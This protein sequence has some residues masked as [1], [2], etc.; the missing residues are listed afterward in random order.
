MLFENQ[1]LKP[2]WLWT[3]FTLIPSVLS[4]SKHPIL[5]VVSF[6]AFRYNFFDTEQLPYMELIRHKGVYA[7]FLVNVFPTKTFTNHH[8]ISTGLYAESH[9]VVGNSFYDPLYKKVIKIGPEMYNYNVDVKP[10]W[11]LNE[12]MGDERYSATVMWPG[13]IFS[14][15]NKNV[16]WRLPFESGYDWHERVDHVITWITDPNKPANLVM[17]YF[18]EPDTHGHAFGPNSPVVKDLIHKLDNI[19]GYLNQQ[20]NSHGLSENV[21]VIFVSDHGMTAVTPP[22]FLN[23]TQYITN[24]TYIW[25]GVSPVI[26]IIPN[27]GFHDTI[28]NSL[29]AAAKENGHFKV[30]NKSEYLERWHLKNN[31]RAAPILVVADIG[32]AFDDLIRDAPKYAEKYNFTL[33]NSSEFGVHGYDYMEPEMHPYFMAIGPKIKQQTKV[34]PFQTVDLFNVFCAILDIPPTD[35]NGT[36][37]PVQQ[38]LQETTGKYSIGTVVMISGGFSFY[39]KLQTIILFVFLTEVIVFQH[40]GFQILVIICVLFLKFYFLFYHLNKVFDI[41]SVFNVCIQGFINRTRIIYDISA[42]SLHSYFCSLP[43]LKGCGYFN[44]RTKACMT[45]L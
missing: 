19:T 26:Q 6:D 43:H 12:D 4:I 36:M 14:Y 8:T 44:N 16:T 27:E 33:T 32:Y 5:I 17:L 29:T 28:Y 38:I 45:N 20:I 22:R 30:Y 37:L 11:R 7:D 1:T 21:N 31:R 25:A 15:Q 35:N 39:A 34:E 42:K 41:L 9:G 23:I 2:S 10:I 13:A 40:F 24:G 3:F 18:E